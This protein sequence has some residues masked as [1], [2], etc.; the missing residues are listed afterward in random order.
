MMEIKTQPILNFLGID[1][2]NVNVSLQNPF[3]HDVKPSIDLS[4]IPKVFYPENRPNDFTIIIEL[5]VSSKDYFNIDVVAFGN[6]TLNR[7][8]ID[9][10]VK[11]FIDVNAPAIMFPYVRSFLST[12]TANLGAGFPPI[13]LPPQ[14]FQGELEVLLPPKTETE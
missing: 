1:I 11:P 14:I 8:S 2:A 10:E 5:N 9:N 7:P 6:F 12:L 13:I 3:N 4:V